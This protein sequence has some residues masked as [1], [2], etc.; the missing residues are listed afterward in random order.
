MS[1]RRRRFKGVFVDTVATSFVGAV[2]AHL[3]ASND[4]PPITFSRLHFKHQVTKQES[5]LI[6]E[7][8]YIYILVYIYRNH[9]TATCVCIF[10]VGIISLERKSCVLFSSS[11]I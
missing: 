3:I 11:Q 6:P 7:S 8:M 2:P 4:L 1:D 9:Y 5:I 10:L